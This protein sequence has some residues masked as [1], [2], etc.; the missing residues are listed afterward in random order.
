MINKKNRKDPLSG[1]SVDN[2]SFRQAIQSLDRLAGLKTYQS[3]L[4]VVHASES[5]I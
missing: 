4:G 2:R 1:F 3:R 5:S